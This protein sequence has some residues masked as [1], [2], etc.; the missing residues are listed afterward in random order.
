MYAVAWHVSQS[1]ARA[2][3][4]WH[5][6]SGPGKSRGRGVDV[7]ACMHVQMS[8]LVPVVTAHV[9]MRNLACAFIAFL[10]H[11][12]CGDRQEAGACAVM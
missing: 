7:C 9:I 4:Q 5:G 10:L 11:R 2:G 8:Q 12:A 6:M 3:A 1:W